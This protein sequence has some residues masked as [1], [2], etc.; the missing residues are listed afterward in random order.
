MLDKIDLDKQIMTRRT[1]VIGAGKL[2]LLFL[3]LGR[4]FY[5]QF[6]KKDEYK[7]LSDKNRIKI[8]L[9][10]P[11]RGD[12]LD[13][14]G[15][16]IA[17]NQTCFNLLLDKNI[18]STYMKEVELISDILELDPDQIL[19]INKRV[20]RSGR[21]VAAIII[22]CLKWSQVA[23]IEERKSEFNALFI[24]TGFN[25]YYKYNEAIAHLIGYLSRPNKIEK[26]NIKLADE[27]FKIGKNGIE[28]F[29]EKYLRGKFG[30]KRIEINALGKYVRELSYN[31]SEHGNNLRLNI[32]AELQQEIMEFLS[33]QGCSVVVMDCTTGHI[34]ISASS[35][36]FDPNQFSKLSNKYW[37]N[38]M[39]NPY[40]PLIDKT[41]KSLYPPGSVFKIVTALAA[42][43][44][45]INPDNK[46]TCTGGKSALG[47]NSFR[48]ASTRGHG[49]LDMANA[50]KYSCN[51][52]FYAISRQIGAKKIMQVA[53]KLGLGKQT[54]IDLPSELAG[55][56]PSEEWKKAKHGTR[57]SVGDTLNLSIGQGFL[58]TTPMQLTRLFAAIASDGKL[59]TP[60][61]AIQKPEYTQINIDP[62]HLDIIKNALFNTVN[63][64]GGSAYLSRLNHSTI[65]M[66]GKTGTAQVQAKKSKSDDLNSLSVAW[67]S[68]NHAIFCGY[69]PHD[70]PKY[71]ITVYFDHGGG[72]GRA[73]VPIAKKVMDLILAK[74]C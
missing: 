51:S 4:M 10:S 47:G 24:D 66:A 37:V 55:F 61:I 45:G 20:K 58:Q 41:I 14:N 62:K 22:D 30:L 27:S 34:L 36:S 38:L 11:A 70:V 73:A 16:I 50:L 21:R 19:E 65:Q 43:E 39:D 56:V 26:E 68:R 74:Y 67:K 28:K 54:G 40:K 59:F 48:C 2:G 71:V 33:P 46:V 3:L 1:F 15:K 12:I 49:A 29:Y 5:M 17:Q 31:P 13:V 6:L 52:Y 7:T 18:S 69:A 9:I 63:T 23:S 42:L 44:A 72:G 25:R 60:K 32:D 53:R 64:P 8:V 57:W 35:P